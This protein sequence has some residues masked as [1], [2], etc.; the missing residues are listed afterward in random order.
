M[1]HIYSIGK[2]I[3]NIALIFPSQPTYELKVEFI[4]AQS[5]ITCGSVL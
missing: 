3:S 4:L 5:Y 1:E 2:W